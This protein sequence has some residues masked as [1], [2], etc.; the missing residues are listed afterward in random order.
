MKNTNRYS[1]WLFSG[2]F[3]LLALTGCHN[4]KTAQDYIVSQNLTVKTVADTTS[5]T[6]VLLDSSFVSGY[7]IGAEIDY[8]TDGPQPLADSVRQ[9]IVRELYGM[10]DWDDVK[11]ERYIPL[12]GRILLDI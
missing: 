3:A 5:I 6:G 2:I 12:H 7:E 8:P 11:E 4:D 1:L 10:F 9:F